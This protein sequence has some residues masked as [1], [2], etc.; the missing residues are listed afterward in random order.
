MFL[1]MKSSSGWTVRLTMNPRHAVSGLEAGLAGAALCPAAGQGSPATG[2]DSGPPT[3][4]ITARRVLTRQS[5]YSAGV[6]N[7]CSKMAQLCREQCLPETFNGLRPQ[8][9]WDA[10]LAWLRSLLHWP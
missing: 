6:G 8:V 7:C 5:P 3:S 9:I 1:A 4:T 2:K 10:A